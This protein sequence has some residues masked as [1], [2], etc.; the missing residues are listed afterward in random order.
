MLTWITYHP[1]LLAHCANGLFVIDFALIPCEFL[2]RG[3]PAELSIQLRALIIVGS[4]TL[5]PMCAECILV[6]GV[7]VYRRANLVNSTE[8]CR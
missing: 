4:Q 5:A 6:Q 8:I 2:S 3:D 7:H 1:V